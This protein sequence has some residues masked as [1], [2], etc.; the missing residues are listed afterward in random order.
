MLGDV[1][2]CHCKKAP[3]EQRSHP[4]VT[5]NVLGTVLVDPILIQTYRLPTLTLAQALTGPGLLKLSRTRPETDLLHPTEVP[6]LW[7]RRRTP[8]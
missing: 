7:K 2:T 3:T 8:R 1:H 6:A 5:D 4:C